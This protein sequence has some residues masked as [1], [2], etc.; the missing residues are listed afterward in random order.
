MKEL[1][2][3][4]NI[5]GVGKPGAGGRIF[6]YAAEKCLAETGKCVQNLPHF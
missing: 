1:K 5:I 6:F 2:K 3:E 4:S